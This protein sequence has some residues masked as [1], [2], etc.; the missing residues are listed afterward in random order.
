MIAVVVMMMMRVRQVTFGRRLA[1]DCLGPAAADRAH[2]GI[3]RCSTSSS[4]GMGVAT[5]RLDARHARNCAIIV[6]NA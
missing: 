5:A 6:S 3:S 2:H 4:P 1:L